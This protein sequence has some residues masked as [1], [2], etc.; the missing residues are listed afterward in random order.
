MSKS[1]AHK[2]SASRAQGI[3]P[4]Y[5]MD[6]LARAKQLEAEGRSVIHLEVGEP[7]FP[8]VEPVIEAGICALQQQQTHYTPA[9]GLPELRNKIA[10]YYQRCFGLDISPQRIVVTPG[11]SGALQLVLASLLDVNDEVLLSDPGYPCNRNI[12]QILAARTRALPVSADSKFQL[13]AEL[14]DQHWQKHTKAAM[15]ATPSN[16]SGSVIGAQALQ[17]LHESVAA[18]GGM[19]IVDEIYQGLVYDAENSTVLALTDDVVVINSFSKYFGMTGWRVGWAVVPEHLVAAIDR[20]AQNLF[21][22]P[23]TLA[24]HAALRALDDDCMQLFDRRVQVFKQRRDYLV[25]ALRDIGFKIAAQPQGAF[26]IYAD[27][28]RFTSDSFSW[29][30]NLLETQGV[31][32][33]PGIDFGEQQA[34]DYVRFAY[35]RP[36]E[37]LETAV[38]RIIKNIN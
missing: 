30:Q 1:S 32:V 6:L 3:K 36:L 11:A 19:L 20:M 21:L 33:T 29:S 24:Q 10:D 4:F 12:A 7:D 25:P 38:K 31:A 22:A 16:P 14:V 13:T 15:V 27:C 5:V 18:K 17:Q 9:L 8:T 28:S 34:G 2:F 37:Q 35:T 23:S 26:Y